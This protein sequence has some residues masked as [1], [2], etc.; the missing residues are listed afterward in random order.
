MKICPFPSPS[1]PHIAFIKDKPR[2]S[3][4]TSLRFIGPNR[5][6]CADFNE[7]KMYLVEMGES[8]LKLI[9]AVPTIIKDGTPVQTDL[10]DVTAD[11]L[12]VV[13]NFYQGT[14]SFYRIQRDSLT[15]VSELKVS[16][17]TGCHG[18][19]FVPGYSDLIWITYCGKGNKYIVIADYKTGRVLHG[20]QMPEQLQDA[21]F[22]GRHVLVPARTDHIS[23]SGPHPGK[24]YSTVYLLQLPENLL[25]SPPI[26]VDT[27]HGEGHLDAMVEFG[28]QA[29][30]ANQYTDE[31][32]IFGITPDEKI[33]KRGSIPGFWLPHGL[34]IRKDG[35]MG[36]TNYG[37]NTLRLLQ[38]DGS[39]KP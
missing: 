37:D 7:K 36:V 11:G 5:L 15:F 34:D 31:V 12:V 24:M 29:Y 14:Q 23:I 27:W 20:L 1:A 26:V 9:A 10:L 21:A 28:T 13:S 19:R 38:L 22:I 16:N 39:G 8:G 2:N 17:F 30:S 25:Q 3:G 18:V 35:L 6:V 4:L 32:D 33:E